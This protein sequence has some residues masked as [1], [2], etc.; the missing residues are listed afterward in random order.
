MADLKDYQAYAAF[1]PYEHMGF[2]AGVA[3]GKTFTGSHFALTCMEDHPELTGLI[4]ANNHDQL[5]QATLRELIYWMDEYG[6]DYELDARPPLSPK[7]FKTYKNVLSV[8]TK[9]NPKIWTHAFTRIMSSPNPLRGIEFAWYWLDETRDTPENTHDVVL[10]R[11]RESHTFRRGLLTST[12]NGEDW[13]YKRFVANARRGQKMYGSI[14]IPTYRG[15][16]KGFLS[17]A[18]YDML[19]STYSELMAMQELDALHVNV[20]GGRAYYAFGPHN[21]AFIAPWGDITPNL[22][23]PL[24]IGCDFNYTPAPCVWMIGQIGPDLLDKRGRPF[25][26]MIHWFGE[27]SGVEKSTPEMTGMLIGRYPGFFYR[28][29][30]DSSGHRGTT[31]NAGRNDYAQIAEVM[32]DA[33]AGFTIDPSQSN[34]LIKDR[35]ENMN[36]LA[37]NALRET[38]MTYNPNQCPLFHSDTKIVGWKQNLNSS[39]GARLDDGGNKQ[40][41][42]ASDGAGYA[43]FKLFP[44]N[45][46][47]FM[48]ETMPSPLVSE[49]FG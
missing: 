17:Q 24:V 47:T 8:R 42:H 44:P 15:V 38:L 35:I 36:R 32:Y 28:I 45:Y 14:H 46:R 26:K 11:M 25:N 30:G 37:R 31:S 48:G 10:S 3:A 41:T 7:K 5:S 29:Y 4:G 19:R 49:L 27:I 6:Y 23:R 22:N 1:S 43:A 13:A 34:P 39:R 9:A 16:E 18:Y 20:R 33:Q 21:E 2:F 12:T 40:A